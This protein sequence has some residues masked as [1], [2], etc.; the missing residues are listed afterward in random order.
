MTVHLSVSLSAG[1]RK[2]CWLD[3]HEKKSEDGS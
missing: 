1:L 3:L 2:Y